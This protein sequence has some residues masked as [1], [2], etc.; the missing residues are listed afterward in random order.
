[1]EF[2]WN[3]E[4]AEANLKKHEVSFDEAKTVFND[5]LFVIFADPDHS[6]EENRFII[7]GESNQNRLL[8]VSYTE[9]L[10]KTRLIS[11]RKATP[12]ERKK[13]E[14]DI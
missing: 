5:P 9:R 13:Y 10:L 6:V 12:S 3:T 11:A 8:V 1:M 2:E 4:K 14:E 7:M